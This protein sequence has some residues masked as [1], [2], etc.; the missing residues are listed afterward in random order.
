MTEESVV[1]RG[2]YSLFANRENQEAVQIEAQHNYNRAS[3]EAVYRFFGKHFGKPADQIM[4][5]EAPFT[6]EKPEDMLALHD[7][8]LPGN[9][10]DYAGL[11]AEWREMVR[12]QSE[13]TRDLAVIRRRL[14]YA[15]S[16]EL[17]SKAVQEID[18]EKIVIGR[19]GRK[20]RVPGQWHAGKGAPLLIVDPQGATA[21]RRQSDD[22]NRVQD[23][24]TSLAFL[25]ARSQEKIELRGLGK[26]GVWCLFAAAVAGLDPKMDLK[27]Q[28]DLA[29]FQ[30][31]DDDFL[32]QFF[33]PDIQRA[34]GLEAAMR[35][36]AAFRNVN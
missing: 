33:V 7:R 6:A 8:K 35:A 20:D 29:G 22:A 14:A 23:I 32:R 17:P 30:G 16:A 10:L 36:T 28:A 21:A 27:L 5:S 31:T 13:Q 15:L 19:G 1:I 18:G 9:A 24:L 2:I 3:R 4:V 11:F 25:R 26:A 34:G 12:R